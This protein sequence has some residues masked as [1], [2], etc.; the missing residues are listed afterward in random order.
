MTSNNNKIIYRVIWGV[1]CFKDFNCVFNSLDWQKSLNI[2]TSYR[3]PSI[4]KIIN[5]IHQPN[6]ITTENIFQ[7]VLNLIHQN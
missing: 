1:G 2:P 7:E 6:N 4:V 5:G 3:Q